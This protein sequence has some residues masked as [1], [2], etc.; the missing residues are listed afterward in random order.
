MT[1]DLLPDPETLRVFM[2]EMFLHADRSSF[3]NLRSFEHQDDKGN[4]RAIHI[5]A[6]PINAPHALDRVIDRATRTAGH[7]RPAVFAP[8]VCTF[9][10][11]GSAAVSNLAN[12][13]GIVAECDERP[14]EAYSTLV[15][16]LG[17]PTIVVASGGLWADPETGEIEDK[18]HFHWRLTDATRTAA[19]HAK[20]REARAIVAR[21]VRSDATA[22]SIVHPLRWAGSVHTKHAPRLST[23]VYRSD[24]EVDLDEALARLREA[25]PDA[26]PAHDQS[27]DGPRTADHADI[28]S[29]MAVI[30]NIDLPWDE[31][32][33][34]GMA[35]F[36]ATEGKGFDVFETW[37]AKSAKFDLGG[38]TEAWNKIVNSPPGAIGAGTIFHAA[39]QAD[40]SWVRP[41]SVVTDG[42]FAEAVA[43]KAPDVF[44]ELASPP[45]VSTPRLAPRAGTFPEALTRVPGLLGDAIDWI[46]ATDRRPNRVLALGPA[47]TALGTIIGRRLAGPTLSGTHLYVIGLAPSGAGKDHGLNQAARLIKATN[48]EQLIGPPE[49]MSQTA[50]V[51]FI[52]RQPLALCVMDELG[53]FLKRLAHKRA[54]PHEQ[55][56]TKVLRSAWG[57]SF[58]AMRTPEWSGQASEEIQSPALSIY[59]VSTPEEFF[60]A[61]QG[62]DIANGFLNRFLLIEAPRGPA[63][64]ATADPFTVPERLR[65]GLIDL[66]LKAN[67]LD[68]SAITNP[69]DETR[70]AVLPWL[71]DAEDVYRAMQRDLEPL[72]DDTE[73]GAFY[74]RTGEM[75]VRLATIR[76]AGR[77]MHG[78]MPDDL[79]WGRDV[80]LWSAKRMV[81]A[82]DEHMAENDFQ[83]DQKKVLALMRRVGTPVTRR[84]MHRG[85]RTKLDVQGLEKVIAVLVASGQIVAMSV[86]PKDG[87]GR[88][89]PTHYRLP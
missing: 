66:H 10:N 77:G 15:P 63:A 2:E 32:K 30:P 78:I 47:L 4:E 70:P 5:E 18:L 37:S 65:H 48:Q 64:H 41:S 88:P 72:R 50:L 24:H 49:F 28:A 33:R 3:I 1:P 34:F 7:P 58:Q 40:P 56:I 35:I 67:R 68:A 38:T 76:A 23:I 19:E 8:P 45:M 9:Q 79:E 22:I 42:E 29:A 27:F 71:N 6:V 52:H 25:C 73:T 60:A 57:A 14:R 61:M 43:L 16:I 54:S 59:G 55:G 12:G 75:A 20:L 17:E 11:R 87:R 89:P 13:L 26:P 36:A 85:I 84:D 21:I 82:A 69:W 46:V 31:W 86:K 62:S 80:A 74:A 81:E 83:G 53:A 39:N 44:A 51:R